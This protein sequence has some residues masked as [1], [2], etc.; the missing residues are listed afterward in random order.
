MVCF[1]YLYFITEE[2]FEIFSQSEESLPLKVFKCRKEGSSYILLLKMC[3]LPSPK[4]CLWRAAENGLGGV[5][6]KEVEKHETVEFS[7]Y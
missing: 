1:N 7:L 2:I 3:I 6:G 5:R 4:S